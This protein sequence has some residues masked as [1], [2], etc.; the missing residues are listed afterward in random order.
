VGADAQSQ[1]DK[2]V[3]NFQTEQWLELCGQTVYNLF[4]FQDSFDRVSNNAWK[5]GNPDDAWDNLESIHDNVHGT[6]GGPEGHLTIFDLSAYD[7]IFW[8]HHA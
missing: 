8:L 7:P 4:A 1:T 2:L 3:S 5:T 6:A